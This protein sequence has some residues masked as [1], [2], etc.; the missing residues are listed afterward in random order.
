MDRIFFFT[1]AVIDIY[2]KI[3]AKILDLLKGAQ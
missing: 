1:L 2:H 3:S